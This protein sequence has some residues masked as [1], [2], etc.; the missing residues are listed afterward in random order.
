M[1]KDVYRKLR[2]AT[3]ILTGRCVSSSI[4]QDFPLNSYSEKC[5]QTLTSGNSCSC[6]PTEGNISIVHGEEDANLNGPAAL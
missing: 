3:L 1:D 5:A 4:L 2:L 6:I